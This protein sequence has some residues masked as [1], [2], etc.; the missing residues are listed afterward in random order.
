M[1]LKLNEEQRRSIIVK[2]GVNIIHNHGGI[3]NLTFE[4]IER[5]ATPTTSRHTVKHWFRTRDALWSAVIDADE[6]GEAKRQADAIG[7]T[8]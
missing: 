4:G 6:T 1:G 8:G 7:W 2:T 3:E 5:H